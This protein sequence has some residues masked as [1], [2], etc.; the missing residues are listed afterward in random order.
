MAIEDNV[1][2]ASMAWKAIAQT[3]WAP[4]ILVPHPH[5]QWAVSLDA[6][7][8]SPQL[9]ARLEDVSRG[10]L[11]GHALINLTSLLDRKIHRGWHKLVGEATDVNETVTVELGG[12]IELIV[13]WCHSPATVAEVVPPTTPKPAKPS[14]SGISAGIS[15]STQ[16]KVFFGVAAAGMAA[17]AGAR[18][19]RRAAAR[20]VPELAEIEK[21][22]GAGRHDR[23]GR[24]RGLAGFGGGLYLREPL[25]RAPVLE[26]R[27]LRD[28]ARC[29]AFLFFSQLPRRRWRW[30]RERLPRAGEQC[31]RWQLRRV[32]LATEVATGFPFLLHG[33][34]RVGDPV[35]F[36]CVGA[37]LRLRRRCYAIGDCV[38][39]RFASNAGTWTKSGFRARAPCDVRVCRFEGRDHVVRL[40]SAAREGPRLL[41]K[42][43][44]C[45]VCCESQEEAWAVRRAILGKAH[46]GKQLPVDNDEDRAAAELC[47]AAGAGDLERVEELLASGEATAEDANG[48]GESAVS[49]AVRFAI[50]TARGR[51]RLQMAR[52]LKCVALL[53]Q[54]GA[55][56]FAASCLGASA[57]DV[58]EAARGEVPDAI[59]DTIRKELDRAA[60]VA[61]ADGALVALTEKD[62][63]RARELIRRREARESRARRYADTGW[64]AE[65]ERLDRRG[66]R[67]S[68]RGRPPVRG[69]AAPLPAPRRRRGLFV[70][71]RPGYEA[72]G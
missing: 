41:Q 63:N 42:V 29:P 22:R 15:G 43:S 13:Q 39:L 17:A 4:E 20:A 69:E 45:R 18:A 52:A 59:I 44:D 68:G 71:E 61:T 7:V 47:R 49:R 54:K 31:A 46:G 2:V 34:A 11:M 57:R 33:A 65:D 64:T 51:D 37:A 3:R 50:E 38:S 14:P 48:A 5:Q 1:V 70:G 35:R 72:A 60:I 9:K 16:K 24:R 40:A 8:A 55:D 6:N 10:E 19:R 58:L 53:M 27:G 66:Q 30:R 36:T 67:R 25:R 26:P 56:P 28:A 62:A 23:G 32:R 12:E 21:G